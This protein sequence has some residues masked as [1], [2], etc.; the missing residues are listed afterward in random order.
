[1][2]EPTDFP[3]ELTQEEYHLLLLALGY[4]A[5]AAGKLGDQLSLQVAL[6][7]A[8]AISRNNPKWR[9]YNLEAEESL[10]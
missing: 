3:I 9:K 5:G 10:I 8:N 2:N 7:L 6:R 1:M 4:A